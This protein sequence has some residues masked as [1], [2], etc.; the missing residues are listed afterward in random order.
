MRSS[1]TC[2]PNQPAQEPLGAKRTAF[3]LLEIKTQV[4][5]RC[6]E[7]FRHAR[8]APSPFSRGVTTG[9]RSLDGWGLG[10]HKGGDTKITVSWQAACGTYR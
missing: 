9:A 3:D 7:S 8:N 4:C 5:Q 2:S 10:L 6:T 1:G